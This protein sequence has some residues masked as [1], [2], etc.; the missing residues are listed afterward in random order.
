VSPEE[1]FAFHAQ[2]AGPMRYAEFG[3]WVATRYSDV[4][5]VL[6]DHEVFSSDELRHSTQP[7]PHRDNPLLRGLLAT[8]PPRH[9]AL[10]RIVSQVFTPRACGLAGHRSGST[11]WN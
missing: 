6:T 8:D 9:H 10:R 1:I 5:R 2:G 7:I 3:A 4:D 11:S